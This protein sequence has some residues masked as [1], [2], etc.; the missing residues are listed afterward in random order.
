MRLRPSLLIPI[1]LAAGPLALGGAAP[2]AGQ[3]LARE[4]LPLLDVA[5]GDT[6]TRQDLSLGKEALT[7]A[8]ATGDWGSYQEAVRRF[9]EAALRSPDLAEPW[10][11]L[12][13]SRLALSETGAS[14][15]ISPTQP[16][17]A[18]N[19]AAWASHI[20]AVLARDPRH[21][22]ALTSLGHVLLPQGDREQP[23]WLVDA[24]TRADS[25]GALTPDLLLIKGRLE[26]Q[27]RRYDDAAADFRTYAAHGGDPSVADLEEARALAGTGDLDAAAAR[28]D[29][30][31]AL[32]TAAGLRLYR[33][34]LEL[35]AEGNE[36]AGLDSAGLG[37]AGRWIARF[38]L[39]RDATDV[40]PEG[41]R[42]REH[43]RRWIVANE[44]YRVVDPDRRLL[45]HEPWAPIAPCVPKDSFNLVQTGAHEGTD[46]LDTR[47]GERILDDRGLMY[48]RHG[49]PLRVVWT[50][51]AGDRARR[52][53]ETADR[54]ELRRA[55]VP[56]DVAE[57]EIALRARERSFSDPG[58][59][60]AE[61]WTYFI[62]GKVRSYLFRGSNWLGTNTPSTLS[63][64]VTSPELALLR[65]QVDPR[66]YTL[67][68]RYDNPL[69]SHVPIS[70][71]VSVQRLAQEVRADLMVGGRTDD[72]PLFFPT[73]VIPAVQ[74]A[75]VGHPTEGNGQVVVAYAV[76]G[77][78]LVPA[79]VDGRFVYPL[80]WRLTAVDSAGRVERLE[81]ELQPS[82]G[83]S[84]AAGEFLSG[85]LALPVPPGR[86]QVG[87]AIYQPDERRGGAIEARQVE[88]D[89]TAVAMSDLILGRPDETVRWNGTPMNPLGTWRRGSAM[90][91]YAELRGVPAGT[92]LT[93][94]IEVRQLDQ[95]SGRPLVR[96]ASDGRSEG[97][98]T[99]I[100]REVDL[101]A[102]RPGRYRLLVELRTPAGVA[103]SRSRE[104]EVVPA[105]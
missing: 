19:R 3:T 11:G 33:A 94:V 55:E 66:F 70:C 34:D 96:V 40:R 80:R 17:G 57:A 104:F 77:D 74:V 6:R 12:A 32:L 88:L 46:S 44:R 41:D 1:L 22:G 45:F 23:G 4:D 73:P 54:A 103:G 31:L 10:F 37:G 90:S 97:T 8:T 24:L 20:R 85:T 50:L 82:R 56:S 35:I 7:R 49:D 98:F 93:T 43:L 84:L 48:L 102:L 28:Y 39:R 71:M 25:L 59:N 68:A 67:W 105:P 51:G 60:S 9:E 30:G 52:E 101:S 69:P 78:R 75:A 89:G 61:V 99:A 38:W 72:H 81:G 27:G 64:D 14:T 63:A 18:G 42:L 13:L 16:L 91:V 92:S 26:R 36:L 86:W 65:A 2:L 53:A 79:R 58:A 29:S 5:Q 62:D 76:A 21:L 100:R 47:A 15:L 87:V 83:D 95:A